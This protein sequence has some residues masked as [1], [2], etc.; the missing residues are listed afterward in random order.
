MGWGPAGSLFLRRRAQTSEYA[1]WVTRWV[2]H[3]LMLGN[4]PWLAVVKDGV[5]DPV[6]AGRCRGPAGRRVA[7]GF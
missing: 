6:I 7:A 1:V 5:R 4:R 2:I 3:G